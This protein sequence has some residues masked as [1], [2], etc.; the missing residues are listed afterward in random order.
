MY[1]NSYLGSADQRELSVTA[2]EEEQGE[3]DFELD[4]ND[5]EVQEGNKDTDRLLE[6][7]VNERIKALLGLFNQIDGDNG[8]IS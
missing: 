4:F 6:Q 1:I 7:L 5:S 2:N 3:D 8:M